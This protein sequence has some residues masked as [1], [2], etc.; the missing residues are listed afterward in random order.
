M[1][2][3]ALVRAGACL[4]D[5]ASLA[6]LVDE[7]RGIEDWL[8]QVR[9]TFH[10]HPELMY[11]EL[12]TSSTIRRLLDEMNIPYRQDRMPVLSTAEAHGLLPTC[13]WACP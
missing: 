10:A 4:G 13:G 7:A 3:L 11:Q 1:A 8:L 12:N 2:V 5:G 9:R 6:H